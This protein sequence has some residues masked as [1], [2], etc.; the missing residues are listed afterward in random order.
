MSERYIR[1]RIMQKMGWS[2]D[3]YR[4]APYWFIAE[5]RGFIATE[6]TARRVSNA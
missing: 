2:Y 6:D 5:I 1:Y 4:T 3:D